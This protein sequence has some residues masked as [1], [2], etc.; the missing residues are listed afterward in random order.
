MKVNQCDIGVCSWSLK[1]GIADLSSAMNKMGVDHVHL[2]V[3]PALVDQ[4]DAYLAA[5]AEPQWAISCTMIDFLQ[6]DYSTLESIKATGGVTPDDCW[7]ANQER[8]RQAVAVTD[9]LKV[10]NLSMHAGFIDEADDVYAKKM[11]DRIRCLADIA[12]EKGLAL[13]L[14]TGQ[15]NASDLVEFLEKLD[16]QAV[17]I[18]FDPANMILYD[19]GDPIEALHRLQ[20]WIKHVHIKDATLTEKP[21]TWGAEVP[22]GQGQVGETEFLQAIET[23]GYQGVLAIER[24]AGDCRLADI[25]QAVERLR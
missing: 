14:E 7:L 17:G 1:M 5:L 4:G 11:S 9:Q 12:G 20:P 15:E 22:W 24:E 2:A 13:L 23:I 10:K 16:H 25:A 3:G 8:F 19:K 21:G 18:N 6:E